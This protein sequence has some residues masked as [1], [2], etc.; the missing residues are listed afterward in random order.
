MSTDGAWPR[1]LAAR[2]AAEQATAALAA[3]RSVEARQFAEQVIRENPGFYL[4]YELRGRAC[5]AN[6]EYAAART[7]LQ[8][9]LARDPP[10]LNRRESLEGLLTEC[11]AHLK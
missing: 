9:A 3:G 2:R 10:Y 7:A 5:L 4:G 8:Q 11:D 1:V 6:G